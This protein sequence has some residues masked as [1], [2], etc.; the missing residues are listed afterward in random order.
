M[1]RGGR[2]LG[3]GCNGGIIGSFLGGV[4]SPIFRGVELHLRLLLLGHLLLFG[5]LLLLILF[6]ST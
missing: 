3:G 5:K 2:Q 6:L 1:L 4:L